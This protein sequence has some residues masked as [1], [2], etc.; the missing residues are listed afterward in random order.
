MEGIV[1]M[2]MNG[3]WKTPVHGLV[4]SEGWGWMEFRMEGRKVYGEGGRIGRDRLT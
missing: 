3:M 2:V 4:V 1:F